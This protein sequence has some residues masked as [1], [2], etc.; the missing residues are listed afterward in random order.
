MSLHI[1]ISERAEKNLEKII[2]YLQSEWSEGVK[3]KFISKLIKTINQIA[4]TP[5]MYPESEIKKNVRKC[6]V[7]KHTVLFYRVNK[8]EIE[9]I[10]IQDTRQNP[11]FLKL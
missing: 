7:T 8:K 11:A 2:T 6:V 3:Q 10:T 5:S 9:I 1:V 4:N